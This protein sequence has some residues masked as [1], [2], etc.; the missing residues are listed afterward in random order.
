MSRVA[1]DLGRYREGLAPLLPQPLRRAGLCRRTAL[2]QAPCNCSA[3]LLTPSQDGPQCL[4][5][6]PQADRRRSAKATSGARSACKTQDSRCRVG[7]AKPCCT[8]S[9]RSHGRPPRLSGQPRTLRI[10]CN[11]RGKNPAWVLG[12]TD[13]VMHLSRMPTCPVDQPL[14]VLDLPVAAM[15]ASLVDNRLGRRSRPRMGSCLSPTAAL[16]M[17]PL[18]TGEY[19]NRD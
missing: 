5:P 7:L 1:I 9:P 6:A 4:L 18:E 12:R 14:Q 17:D 3:G 15:V 16:T 11:S 13:R 2:R 10:R 19:F 8:E